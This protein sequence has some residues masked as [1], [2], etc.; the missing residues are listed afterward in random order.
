VK[1]TRTPGT[2]RR[3]VMVKC[4]TGTYSRPD[5][6][7]KENMGCSQQQLE[8]AAA[9]CVAKFGGDIILYYCALPVFGCTA[10]TGF[11]NHE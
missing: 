8:K 4:T 6:E 2:C 5:G 11:K 10:V 7:A 9:T 1:G 3:E